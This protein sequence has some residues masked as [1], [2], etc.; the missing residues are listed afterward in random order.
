MILAWACQLTGVHDADVKGADPVTEQPGVHRYARADR[1]GNGVR[2]II[3]E[4][5]PLPEGQ[6]RVLPS[7]LTSARAF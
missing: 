7:I 6:H 3:V 1:A 4:D 5:R 2:T